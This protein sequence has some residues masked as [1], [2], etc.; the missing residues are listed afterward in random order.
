MKPKTIIALLCIIHSVGI[1]GIIYAPTREFVLK[2][3]PINLA[4]S[5]I[6]LLS[7]H[8]KWSINTIIGILLVASC[9]FFLEVV[10]IKTKAIFGDY[11]YGTTLGYAYFNVPLAM[12]ANWLV[13]I[14]STRILAVKI[15][16]QPIL[17]ALISATIMVGID[18]IIEPVAVFMNMWQWQS[19]L[20]PLQNY[21]AW[22]IAAFFIQLLFVNVEK[23]YTNQIAI[24]VLIIQTVFF[25][26]IRLYIFLELNY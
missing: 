3:T 20:I 10:G 17:V 1:I 16:S 25:A 2:L 14:Y 24:S 26:L 15:T 4:I 11:T 23:K 12:G 22:F 8:K 6:S 18:W 19:S 21:I 5:L 7:F 13:L 9:G